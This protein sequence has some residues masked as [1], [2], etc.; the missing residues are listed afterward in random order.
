[1][2]EAS[3]RE[4]LAS[5]V[6][7]YLLYMTQNAARAGRRAVLLGEVL[8]TCPFYCRDLAARASVRGGTLPMGL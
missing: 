8:R 5:M 3:R 6:S 4:I 2:T 1:M 7:Q